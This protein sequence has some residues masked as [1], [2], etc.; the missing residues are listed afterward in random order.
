[1][2]LAGADAPDST[3]NFAWAGLACVFVYYTAATIL[4]RMRP[5]PVVPTRYE[6]PPGASPAVAA[7]LFENGRCERAF[8]AAIAS[9]AVKGYLE[10]RQR[11]DWFTLKR[12]REP[13]DLLSPEESTA[14]TELIPYGDIYKFSDTDNS[15]L[16]AAFRK[17]SGVL[18]QITEPK[19][20]S[21]NQ[22]VWLIGVFCLALV[23]LWVALSIP[24]GERKA[25]LGSLGSIVYIGLWTVLGGYAL[26]AALRAWPLTLRRVAT[27]LPTSRAPRRP[28]GWIDLQPVSLS[29][30]AIL[31]F[32]LLAT[33]ASSRFAV[34]VVACALVAFTFRTVLEAP[35][36]E[37]RKLV[38]ALLGFR[39]F[40][41]R[42]ESDRLD[43]QNEVG[44]TP[45]QLDHC[46]PYAV[47][48]DVEHSWGEEFTEDLIGM[49]QF[50]RILALQDLP[51]PRIGDSKED[52]TDFG[53]SIIQLRLGSR[54]KSA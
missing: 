13:D 53:D 4:L 18:E 45:K 44:L 54:N 26:M 10:I 41:A 2:T 9:L 35:T 47:A 33:T 36:T 19:L 30:T 42:A 32:F 14:L 24:I 6:P 46:I 29:A 50:D 28:L 43:R 31:A 39:E 8:A 12:L 40:L 34:L 49:I 38:S 5:S 22:I 20:I 7:Y 25:S 27:L 1:M 15:R 48:L 21:S 3:Y 23:S 51:A 11:K 52:D 37:G 17:F 16:C